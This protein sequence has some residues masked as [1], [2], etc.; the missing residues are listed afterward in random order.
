[1]TKINKNLFPDVLFCVQCFFSNAESI[2]VSGTPET[3]LPD[4]KFFYQ[5]TSKYGLR[6]R[7][8]G[9]SYSGI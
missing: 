2:M 7:K 9:Y 4:V 1:M 8:Y 6:E 5:F 3:S